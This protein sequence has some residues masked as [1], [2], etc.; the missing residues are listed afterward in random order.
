MGEVKLLIGG[1]GGE[2][3]LVGAWPGQEKSWSR[4]RGMC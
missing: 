1:V 4:W 2:G 3:R